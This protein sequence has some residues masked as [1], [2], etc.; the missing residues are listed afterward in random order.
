M[1]NF[2]TKIIT[3]I[4]LTYSMNSIAGMTVLSHD[5]IDDYASNNGKI[6]DNELALTQTDPILASKLN[7]GGIV[8]WKTNQKF[9][10]YGDKMPLG[11]N[12]NGLIVK[13]YINDENTF[14]SI[15]SQDVSI[16]SKDIPMW[17]LS[18]YNNVNDAKNGL[19]NINIVKTKTGLP[20]SFKIIDKDNNEV[21]VT[22]NN[23]DVSFS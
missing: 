4:A 14:G 2:K 17:I 12:E 3:L 15:D 18:K 5:E 13:S 7:N 22:I 11:F 23:G 9:E 19:K 16:N 8:E 1:S 10:I 6:I 21:D 20:L